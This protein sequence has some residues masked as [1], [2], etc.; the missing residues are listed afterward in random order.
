[1][2]EVAVNLSPRNLNTSI[3]YVQVHFQDPYLIVNITRKFQMVPLFDDLFPGHLYSCN[4]QWVHLS[5]VA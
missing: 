2:A 3:N 1:M 4:L 5:A